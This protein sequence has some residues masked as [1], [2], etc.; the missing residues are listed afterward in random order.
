MVTKLSTGPEVN[1]LINAHS[2][3]PKAFRQMGAVDITVHIK[4]TAT[5][6][7][8]A[9]FGGQRFARVMNGINV[10]GALVA[11]GKIN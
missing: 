5:S 2:T 3:R 1:K 8:N 6:K 10:A 4:K 11:V 9:K 7:V